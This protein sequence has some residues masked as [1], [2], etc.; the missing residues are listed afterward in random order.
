MGNFAAL[1]SQ[2]EQEVKEYVLSQLKDKFDVVIHTS[3]LHS[4]QTQASVTRR[5][6]SK[7]NKVS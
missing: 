1:R 4:E 2:E 3:V 6:Q 5:G 7:R